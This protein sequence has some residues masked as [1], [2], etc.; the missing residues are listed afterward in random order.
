MIYAPVRVIGVL[1]PIGEQ[2]Y[3]CPAAPRPALPAE[4]AAGLAVFGY[5]LLVDFLGGPARRAAAD[6][7]AEQL[8]HAERWLHIDAER[9]LNDWLHPHAASLRWRTTSTPPPM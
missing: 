3:P 9:A 5:Y 8:T 1:L 6:R 7:N 4:L 2:R